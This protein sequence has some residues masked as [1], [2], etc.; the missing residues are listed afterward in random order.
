MDRK[1]IYLVILTVVLVASILTV[2][3][4]PKTAKIPIST[5]APT[6]TRVP[7][8]LCNPFPAIPGEIIC[9]DAVNTVLERYPGKI[10]K[11][12]KKI[13]EVPAEEEVHLSPNT[14]PQLALKKENAWIISVTTM[15][16]F[17]S[18]KGTT[19]IF[20]VAVSANE[21]KILVARPK[22]EE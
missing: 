13:E 15:K 5:T 6:P 19:K 4:L 17:S 1:K 2:F 11:I 9:Q 18:P 14:P 21:K 12:D 7:E 16:D 22:L 8:I 3:L 10:T 20:D